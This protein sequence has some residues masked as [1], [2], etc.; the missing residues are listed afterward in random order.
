M[1]NSRDPPSFKSHVSNVIAVIYMTSIICIRS[2]I[3]CILY[4][5]IFGG[6]T[7]IER[8][9]FDTFIQFI[10][11]PIT[12]QINLRNISYMYQ[13]F[14]ASNELLS[15]KMGFLVKFCTTIKCILTFF[16]ISCFWIISVR[17]IAWRQK[18]ECF[19]NNCTIFNYFSHI[20]TYIK[21]ISWSSQTNGKLFHK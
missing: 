12:C 4:I 9:N 1:P 11:A 13:H 8:S 21:N 7:F 20:P 17:F 15:K 3:F 10:F 6:K 16:F 18:A 5:S 19:I 14:L 2:H